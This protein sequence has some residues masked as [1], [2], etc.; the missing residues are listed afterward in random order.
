MK[1]SMTRSKKTSVK[2]QNA[3][4]AVK[5]IDWEHIASTSKSDWSKVEKDFTA[6]I[7]FTKLIAVIL[8]LMTVGTIWAYWTHTNVT[9]YAIVMIMN[10][11]YFF[12][13]S[14]RLRQFLMGAKIIQHYKHDDFH[15]NLTDEQLP[16]YTILVPVF[17]EA[18]VIPNLIRSLKAIDYPSNKMEVLFLCEEED[19]E[20]YAAIKKETLPKDFR[21]VVVPKS[22]PQTKGKA[23]N[24]GLNLA[25]GQIVTIFDAE[26]RP[27]PDQLKRVAQR[28]ARSEE[29]VVCI[30]ARLYYY[31]SGE[32]WL[33]SMFNFEYTNLFNYVLPAMTMHNQPI[34]L[35]GSSNHFKTSFLKK[36]HG[37]DPYNVTEDADLGVRLT[38]RGYKTKMVYSFT[39]EEAVLNFRAWIKQRSRWFKGY[40]HTFFVYLRHPIYVFRHYGLLGYIGLFSLLFLSP[41]MLA[42]LPLLIFLSVKIILGHY[43]FVYPYDVALLLFT[44]FN[45]FYGMLSLWFMAYI[46][47]Y[48]QN[49]HGMKKAKYWYTYPFYF[50]L[51]TVAAVIAVYLLITKPHKWEKTQH[52]VT[53]VAN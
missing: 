14:F 31:N 45:L 10:C 41:F 44:W 24:Y 42:M 8:I 17:K 15:V 53:K 6:K 27:E 4:K 33:S 21:A 5:K 20:T 2:P 26:D 32:N 11:L 1:K 18:E 22:E 40:L 43:D 19:K 50:I 16:T 25:K 38:A 23:S 3:S 28:F 47:K 49:H 48:V 39:G 9:V 34:P 35:G 29:H 37:W 52:G 12:N 30:Q 51:H 46:M 7:V 13:N 36:L